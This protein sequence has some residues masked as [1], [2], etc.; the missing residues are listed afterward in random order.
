MKSKTRALFKVGVLILF[1][2]FAIF[3]ANYAYAKSKDF[4]LEFNIA[5]IP[6]LA[7]HSTPTA[8]INAEGTPISTA[9]PTQSSSGFI[10]QPWDGA[11]RVIW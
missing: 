8:G 7:I 4:F 3:A 2:L 1:I 5:Q 10:P 9:Y 11:S 6:G